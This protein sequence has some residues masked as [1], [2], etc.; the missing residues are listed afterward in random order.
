VRNERSRISKPLVV[1]LFTGAGGLDIG[2]ERA[3]FVHR[4]CVEIDADARRTIQMNRPAWPLSTCNDVLQLAKSQLLQQARLRTR[5]LTLLAGGPPC[6]PFSKAAYWATGSTARLN[7]SRAKTLEAYLRVVEM[8]LPKVLLLENVTGIAYRKKD[9]G[10]QFLVRGVKRINR[11][12]GT[13]YRPAWFSLD[14]AA[15]GVPQRR[16][17]VFLIASRDGK[18]IVPPQPTHGQFAPL[19]PLTTAW[20]A[21]G[22]TDEKSFSEELVPQGKWADLLPSIPEGK[23]YLWHTPRGGGEPLFGWRTRY[24]SFLLKLQRDQPS[25]TIPATPGPATGPFHWRGRLLSVRELCRLQT[26]PDDYIICGNRRSAQRQVGNAVPC[27]IGELLGLLIRSQI[28]GEAVQNE[29]TMIPTRR[30]TS[31]ERVAIEPVSA[32][33]LALVGNHDSHPGH[34]LGPAA[35]LRNQAK[36]QSQERQ[37]ARKNF[38]TTRLATFSGS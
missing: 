27:A 6:A 28:F 32:K 25:W 19:K 20:D 36:A 37:R 10:M 26:F 8:T 29:L 38:R 18:L 21:I 14:A 1:S 15:F 23:N 3:G 2:L 4:L 24:W 30:P 33:Y 35:R 16:E 5:E 11:R 17:R 12:H 13:A 7:D 9:E 22:D 34:G 31:S